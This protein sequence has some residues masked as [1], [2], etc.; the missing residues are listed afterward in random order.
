MSVKFHKRFTNGNNV[1]YKYLEN[2]S[3]ASFSTFDDIIERVLFN[4]MYRKNVKNFLAV[5]YFYL[6]IIGNLIFF[7]LGGD[8]MLSGEDL[9]GDVVV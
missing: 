3:R 8:Y 4:R 5:M 2:C 6:E 1:F 7:Y 9:G